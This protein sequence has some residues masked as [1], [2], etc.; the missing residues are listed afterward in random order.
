ML[1]AVSLHVEKHCL[2]L[3]LGCAIA[4]SDC[5]GA[6]HN[7][8]ADFSST[9]RSLRI[10]P[11]LAHSKNIQSCC[12]SRPSTRHVLSK[13]FR[14]APRRVAATIKSPLLRLTPCRYCGSS[15]VS[16]QLLSELNAAIHEEVV[17]LASPPKTK[18]RQSLSLPL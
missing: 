17:M 18:P 11:V 8:H 7:S 16:C 5:H 3:R 15:K 12:F 4:T 2:L 14:F 6:C 1:L 10:S 13:T 9:T